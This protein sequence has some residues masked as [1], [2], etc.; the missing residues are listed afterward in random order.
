MTAKK[1]RLKALPSRLKTLDTSIAR[2]PVRLN[3]SFYRSPE[4]R[5]FSRQILHERG[6]R[7]ERP[8]CGQ[9][10]GRMICDH[11]VP[12]NLGGA[13]ID[14]SNVQVLC[15]ACHQAKTAADHGYPRGVK[16]L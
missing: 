10:Q 15:H 11:I 6:R 3:D 14:R 4:W 7:C 9:T 13:R 5:A 2:S 12:L 8:N 1:P 16:S